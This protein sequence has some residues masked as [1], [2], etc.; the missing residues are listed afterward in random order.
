MSRGL[1]V[2]GATGSACAVRR[3]QVHC[4]RY[5]EAYRAG[6]PGLDPEEA[7]AAWAA[8]GRKEARDAAH[9]ES[10]ASTDRRREDMA[11]RFATVDILED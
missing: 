11:A 10:V 9:A 8:G 1:C 7:Y 4:T 2:C 6:L 3:H 5:A